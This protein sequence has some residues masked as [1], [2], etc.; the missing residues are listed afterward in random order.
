MDYIDIF[1][2]LRT[3]DLFCRLKECKATHS[4]DRWISKMIK[5]VVIRLLGVVEL[6]SFSL[7]LIF[8]SVYEKEACQLSRLFLKI[9]LF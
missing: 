1:Y 4:V 7:S 9:P 2:F 5:E 3:N 6:T 8:K